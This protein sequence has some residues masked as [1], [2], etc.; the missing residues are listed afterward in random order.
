MHRRFRLA[1]LAVS[2]MLAGASAEAAYTNFEVAHVHPIARTPDGTRLVAVNTP[3]AILEVFAIAPDGRLVPAADIPVGLEPVSVIARTDSEVWVVN[4]VSDS[5]SIVDLTVGAVI[6]TLRVGDEPSDVAFAGGKAFVAISGEDSVWVYDLADL[7]QP[8][9]TV[10]VFADAP[11][12]L[13]VSPDGTTVY[14]VALMSGNQTA[15]VNA[16]IIFGNDFGIDPARAA[17]LGIDDMKCDGAP[18]PAY[19]P[20]PTGIMRNCML[21]DPP[22]PDGCAGPD[23]GVPQVSLIVGWD[24]VAS[25]WLDEAGADWSHCLP[26][27]LPDQDLFAID[28]GSLAVTPVAHVGTALF[29]VSV[30][31]TDGTLYIPNTDARNL[32]RFEHALGVRG[33]VVDNRLALVDP[34]TF[35]VTPIDLNTHI[36]RA[37]DP[38]TNMAERRASISQPGMIAW[39]NDGSRAFMTGF[40]SAKLFEIDGACVAGSCV[41]GADRAAP[42]ALDV[43]AGPTGVV[44][45]ADELTAYVLSR[46]DNTI[47]RI[48]LTTWGVI[49]TI[50]LHDPSAGTVV[51]GRRLLYDSVIGSGHGDASCASCHLFGDRDG[52]AW[53]LGDPTGELT[54]YDDTDDNVRFILP[55]PPFTPCP[56]VDENCGASHQGF[57]PQKGPMT[58]QT[59]RGMLEPLHWRGDRPTMNAFNG[60]FVALMGTEDVDPGPGSAGLSAADMEA[61]RQFAL[62]IAFPPNPHRAVDDTI[63]DAD[64]PIPGTAQVGNP[65]AGEQSYMRDATDG[66]QPCVACHTLPF[67]AGGGQLGGVAPTTPTAA[68]AAALFNGDNDLSPHSDLKVPHL[69]NLYQKIGPTFSTGV[70]EDQKNGFGAIHDGTVP[71][72]LTFFSDTVFTVDETQIRNITSF[73][74]HFPTGTQPCVGQQVTLPGG[75]PPTGTA[76]EESLLTTLLG[77]ADADDP[78]RHGELIA[79]VL[80]GGRVRAYQLV[81]GEWLPDVAS[82]SPLATAAL[83][84]AAS[85]AITFMCTPI[86]SGPRLGGD[87][88]Q[89]TH[90]NGD[91]CAPAAPG[92]WTPVQR[93]TNLYAVAAP[94]TRLSWD[95]QAGAGIDPFAYEVVGGQLSDLRASGL[96][97]A[98]GC[99]AGDLTT[100]QWDDAQPEPPAGDGYFYFLR[101]R[102]ACGPSDFGPGRTDIEPLD[103]R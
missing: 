65:T 76:A 42:R 80:D 94:Q 71:D 52:L 103:C 5:V 89:D 86:D 93:V 81:A 66:T 60:A 11:R 75:A 2:V 1:A 73:V 31:P 51:D 69:R 100:E 17:A 85:S 47:A 30:R 72:L 33:H 13:A 49:D 39:L 18:P 9:Q 58:T 20:L 32:V 15:A 68:A 54:P 101:A 98:T 45:A 43:G 57:D 19:P 95:A 88:D 8:P 63:P 84:S 4:H 61:F 97:P 56:V 91:D 83:R 21:N 48:D 102:N 25:A 82:E 40:G 64:V 24:G 96:G 10:D 74:F 92:T 67:G 50:A 23:Y 3:D 79:T 37:S 22:D 46:F 38:A 6:D 87:R 53:D 55:I 99:L 29:D 90:K 62:D 27:L 34:T 78:A 14:V 70:P 26:F 77:I 59:L 35:A 44:I 16:N 28:A 41:F 7:D 12:A 36:D